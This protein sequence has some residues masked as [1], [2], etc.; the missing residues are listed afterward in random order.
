MRRVLPLATMLALAACATPSRW[1]K[2]GVD[3]AA[4]RQD[5]DDCRSAAQREALR[6]YSFPPFPYWG[7][8][9]GFGRRRGYFYYQPTWDSERFFAE[10]RL[11]AFCMRSRGYE[12]VKVEEQKD[13]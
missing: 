9:W 5:F 13:K 3:Q 10:N 8:Y 11:A 4:A 2:P 12:L 6:Y 1:E 7:P